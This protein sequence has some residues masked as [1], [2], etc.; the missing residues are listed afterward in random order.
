M[1]FFDCLTCFQLFDIQLIKAFSYNPFSFCKIIG[2]LFKFQILFETI[3]L[4]RLFN[5]AKSQFYWLQNQILPS[6]FLPIDFQV[7]YFVISA[8]IGEGNGTPLQ[9]SCLENPMDGGAW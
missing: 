1:V 3:L 6:L 2:N 8:L 5:L 4:L 9:Y 7:S